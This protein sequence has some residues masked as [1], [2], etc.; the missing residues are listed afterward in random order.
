MHM[1][2]EKWSMIFAA[3]VRSRYEYIGMTRAEFVEKT[4]YSQSTINNWLNGTSVPKATDIDNS[5]KVLGCSVSYLFD[6][7]ER[8]E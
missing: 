1:T 3:R 2:R 4:G 6:F 8:V 5:A 7:R